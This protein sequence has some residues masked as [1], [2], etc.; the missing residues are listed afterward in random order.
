V[1]LYAIRSGRYLLERIAQATT[2]ARHQQ[3]P[4]HLC[5]DTGAFGRCRKYALSNYFIDGNMKLIDN[6]I[7]LFNLS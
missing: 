7:T 1:W 5:R 3:A 2:S 4:K 6:T